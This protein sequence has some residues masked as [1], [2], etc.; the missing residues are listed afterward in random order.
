MTTIEQT[1]TAA[2]WVSWFWETR[3]PDWLDRVQDHANGGVYDVLDI[4]GVA[5]PNG[6]KSILTQGRTLFSF[7]HLALLSGDP[8]LVQAARRQAGMLPK[9]RKGPGLYRRAINAAGHPT[10]LP[11]DEVA[12]SYDQCF[13]ILGLS[14]WNK[15]EPSAENQAEIDACWLSLS[16][17][18]TDPETGLLLEDDTVTDPAA[19]DA[20]PRS[21]NPHMHL[22]EACLQSY[23]MTGDATWL[24]RA[25]TLRKIALR[26]FLDDDTDSLA[27]F[28]APDLSPLAGEAGGRREPGHQFEWAWLLAREAEF[29]GDNTTRATAR[30][31]V[32]FAERFGWATSGALQGT[33]FD[34]VWPDGRVMDGTFLLW[35]QTEAIKVYAIRHIAGDEA[36]GKQAQTLLCLMFEHWFADHPVWVNRVSDTGEVIWPEALTRLFYHLVIALT[37]GAR[38]GLWPGIPGKK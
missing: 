29:T 3:M 37:E 11:A 12:R 2:E 16:T 13:I 20:P 23:E 33:A 36:A 18:L 32:Q 27:E 38:A 30:R 14:T 19:P 1:R 4:D 8:A 31:L 22:Y 10:G 17:T 7:A 28:V 34:A 21:Q 6:E 26:H 25:T 24:T 5:I 9:F 15:I 35:P